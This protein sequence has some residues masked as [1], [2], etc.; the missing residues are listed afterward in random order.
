MEANASSSSSSFSSFSSS[1]LA[2]L[3][4][5]MKG[6]HAVYNP[7]QL[8]LGSWGLFLA[9]CYSW[10]L[11][12]AP[13][14]LAFSHFL[15]FDQN[16]PLKIFVNVNS[17]NPNNFPFQDKTFPG[18]LEIHQVFVAIVAIVAI[19]EIV[20][21]AAIVAI[22]KPNKKTPFPA[23]GPCVGQVRSIYCFA[24]QFLT[25]FPRWLPGEPTL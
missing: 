8:S 17:P 23:A 12:L 2:D 14:K 24:F 7:V 16:P 19:V 3:G 20:A 11:H 13:L 6:L 4:R 22:P 18:T 5:S 21:I 1:C 15:T 9:T 10:N 25:L